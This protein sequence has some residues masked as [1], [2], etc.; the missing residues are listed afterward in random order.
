MIW[1]QSLSALLEVIGAHVFLCFPSNKEHCSQVSPC[2]FSLIFC[3]NFAFLLHHLLFS[4]S[5]HTSY[6]FTVLHSARSS[7]LPLSS[8]S[9]FLPL[10]YLMN[11]CCSM[12]SFTSFPCVSFPLLCYHPTTV[13]RFQ[14][15][16]GFQNTVFTRTNTKSISIQHKHSTQAVQQICQ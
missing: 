3:F 8:S 4:D 11:Y 2:F 9:H 6:Y 12:H 16:T 7:S 5:F 1:L 14:R 13:S 10:S 15:G